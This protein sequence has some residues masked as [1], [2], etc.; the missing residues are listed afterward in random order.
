MTTKDYLMQVRKMDKRLTIEREKLDKL[1]SVIEYRSPSF[2]GAGTTGGSDRLSEA[3]A[4]IVEREQRVS[5]LA[6]LYAERYKEIDA[7]IHAIDC[8]VLAEILERRYLLYQKWEEIAAA[9]HRDLRW[10]YRLH[11]KALAKIKIDH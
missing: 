3:V 7:A 6:M 4:S 1:R 10:V 8:E 9:M 2:D 11:G 5:E